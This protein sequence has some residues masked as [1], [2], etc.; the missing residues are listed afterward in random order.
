MEKVKINI[1]NP[2]LNY[3]NIDKE[4]SVVRFTTSENYIPFGAQFIDAFSQNI[5]SKSVVFENGR[6]LY[7]LF[8][9]AELKNINFR[10]KIDKIEGAEVLTF[11]ILK[12]SE[13][14]LMPIHLLVQL[15]IN[16]LSSPENHRLRFNNLTGKLFLYNESLFER[17]KFKDDRLIAKIPAIEFKVH[18][19]LNIELRTTTFTSLLLKPKLDFSKKPLSKYA[20]YTYSHAT[21]A[22]RRILDGEN[23]D[24]KDVFII[25]QEP[26]KKT[27]IPFL[28]FS[29]LDSFQESKMGFMAE[30]LEKI[31]DKLS[32]YLKLSFKEASVKNTFRT[33]DQNQQDINTILS[34]TKKPIHIINSV[35]ETAE[36]YIEVFQDTL[37]T[38]LPTTKITISETHKSQALNIR[39]VHNK[40]YYDKNGI[41]DKYD[42]SLIN[43]QHLTI[44]DFKYNNK[45]AVKAI[46]K[47]L[48]IKWD[49]DKKQV[50]IIDWAQYNFTDD[51]VF[52][53][54]DDE[55]FI[56]LKITPTGKMQFEV[57]EQTL[58]NQSEFDDLIS[59][60]DEDSTVEGVVKNHLGHINIIKRTG[61]YTLPNFSEIYGQLKAE[62]KIEKF[63]IS[64]VARWLSEIDIEDKH[65]DHYHALFN[66]WSEEIISKTELLQIIDHRSVKKKLSKYILEKTGI[67]VKSYMRDQSKYELMDSN[68]DIHSSTEDGKLF[69]YVGTI[70]NGMRTKIG[71][72]SIIRKISG[73]SDAPIFFDDMLPLMNVDFVRYGDLT[74]V[75]FPFKYLREWAIT[76]KKKNCI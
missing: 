44:E 74:V 26:R 54:K 7:T 63:K 40:N 69:Y 71:R 25:K 60:F 73:F 10:E 65:K 15:L 41:K 31:E 49:I 24:A 27:I 38:I 18:R 56:F 50:S 8:T 45:S 64:D 53:I 66:N 62:N 21:K 5:K 72:A 11:S 35:G 29:E 4:F 19:D 52:G 51:F 9:K 75:P 14:Q 43:T 59:I 61:L 57:K 17:R 58:F 1:V 22:M 55:Q 3:R 68:L 46:L 39:L 12:D 32:A 34:Q 23:L 16:S 37:N 36:D 70:G 67:V 76:S 13:I 47:E 30:T 6:S 2:K 48:L 33:A 20:K 28:D 42:S